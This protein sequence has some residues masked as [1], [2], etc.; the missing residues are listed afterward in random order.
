M[1]G[2]VPPAVEF[3]GNEI[4]YR[5]QPQYV[6]DNNHPIVPLIKN[7]VEINS[8]QYTKF[9]KCKNYLLL[10]ITL[11]TKSTAPQHQKWRKAAFP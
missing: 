9:H 2:I 8:N 4:S 6:W 7:N 3:N 1:N 11:Q 10:T 5:Y